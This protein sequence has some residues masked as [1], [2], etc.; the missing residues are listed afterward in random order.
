[1]FRKL[2]FSVLA[3]AVL[4]ILVIPAYSATEVFQHQWNFDASDVPAGS[5]AFRTQGGPGGD[6]F[7]FTSTFTAGPNTHLPDGSTV[8]LLG[9]YGNDTTGLP[10]AVQ[11]TTAYV[12]VGT[13][14][15][16]YDLVTI[17]FQ[18]WIINTWDGD[19]EIDSTLGPDF[20]QVGISSGNA[21]AFVAPASACDATDS[22]VVLCETFRNGPGAQSFPDAPFYNGYG[23]GSGSFTSVLARDGYSIYNITLTE[24][25][26]SPTGGQITLYFRGWQNQETS[27]ESWAISNV[28]LTAL[29]SN[30][31]PGP[32]PGPGDPEI[33]EPSTIVL[34]GLGLAFIAFASKRYRK[35]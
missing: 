10:Y 35:A 7:A 26:V 23:A 1:M 11:A 2:A 17:T 8:G 21:S 18:L 27:D 4:G 6:T 33:P 25:P 34:G 9:P 28:N 29:L 5:P 3:V 30:G 14:D 12:T 24:V 31:D 22:D 19:G 15:H 32:G 16:D 13:A 20:F